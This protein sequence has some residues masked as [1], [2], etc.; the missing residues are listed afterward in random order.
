MTMSTI[1]LTMEVSD[2]LAKRL[3]AMDSE[4]R[5]R[6]ALET[7]DDLFHGQ[8]FVQQRREEALPA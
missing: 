3:V 1:T 4:R 8:R 7:F 2:D 5:Q 6:F